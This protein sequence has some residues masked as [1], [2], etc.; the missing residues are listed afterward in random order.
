MGA[1]AV[2]QH[3]ANRETEFSVSLPY[4][5]LDAVRSAMEEEILSH[6]AVW[7]NAIDFTYVTTQLP[8]NACQISVKTKY[9]DP[10]VNDPVFVVHDQFEFITA[11]TAGLRLYL[12]HV[13]IVY[14]NRN[15]NISADDYIK[16]A[17]TTA[18]LV[19]N[20]FASC[21]CK[22]WD[23]RENNISDR[24][25]F[26]GKIV[27]FSFYRNL[28]DTEEKMR[29][30][31]CFLA[32]QAEEI[33]HNAGGDPKAILDGVLQWF[34]RNVKYL[35]TN[36][37]SDR[38]IIGL[39]LNKTAICQGIA[40]TACQLLRFCGIDARYISGNGGKHAWNM[41]FLNGQWTHIDYTYELDRNSR[42]VL[43]PESRFREE[44]TW[45]ENEYS[46]EKSSSIVNT[47]KTL[48]KSVLS[49]FPDEPHLSINGC[50]MDTTKS[51]LPCVVK[52][53]HI[54]VSLPTVMSLIGG[55]YT[56]IENNC[57]VFID[58][59]HYVAPMDL[60]V[61]IN[62]HSYMDITMFKTLGFN[63]M[64]EDEVVSLQRL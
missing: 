19:N 59:Q 3:L 46:A 10:E 51:Y 13:Y 36:N 57:H 63:I 9:R 62:Q 33:A 44:H 15:G 37:D 21:A 28:F 6:P 40:A 14:D 58:N 43:Q 60:L 26:N 16:Y 39:L 50:T 56:K 1:E 34:R 53:N 35:K 18:E 11:L 47:R 41:V 24:I 12:K 4:C 7:A 64:V 31:S 20:E 2:T 29:N 30:A 32:L 48:Q 22:Y 17:R 38:S 8:Q 55:Y 27:I 23:K 5:D 49:L 61:T 42:S 25:W 52:Q 54:F 45:D